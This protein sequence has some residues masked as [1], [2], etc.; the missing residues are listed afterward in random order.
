MKRAFQNSKWRSAALSHNYVG[1]SFSKNSIRN[2]NIWL[3]VT[4]RICLNLQKNV[5]LL[6]K[7]GLVDRTGNT[8]SHWKL[9]N[10][11]WF[12]KGH[13]ARKIQKLFSNSNVYQSLWPIRLRLRQHIWE[14]LRSALR[15]NGE[16]WKKYFNIH[17]FVVCRVF[18]SIFPKF[19]APPPLEKFTLLLL[20]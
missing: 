19:F 14:I 7:E 8:R 17:F 12:S 5:L 2:S 11:R 10:L 18:C 13:A 20:V 6:Q 9:L 15:Y 4:F 3:S 1:A 16:V